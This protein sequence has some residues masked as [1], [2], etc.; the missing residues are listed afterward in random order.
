MCVNKIF[1]D[2]GMCAETKKID[3]LI[4]Y[5]YRLVTYELEEYTK[6]THK[7][8]VGTAFEKPTHPPLLVL[9]DILNGGFCCC[10]GFGL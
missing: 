3:L 8:G 9:L 10:L 7:F 5:L 1:L 2:T 4:F 6:V